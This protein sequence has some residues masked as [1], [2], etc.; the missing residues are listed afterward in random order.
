[1]RKVTVFCVSSII[2]SIGLLFLSVY[3]SMQ[4]NTD[5]NLP[6]Y[7]FPETSINDYD[8]T[9]FTEYTIL[10]KTLFLYEEIESELFLDDDTKYANVSLD[11]SLV[12]KG[13]IVEKGTEIGNLDD[14]IIYAPV[15]GRVIE[16]AS[17]DAEGNV[18]L[19]SILNADALYFKAKIHQSLYFN[20]TDNMSFVCELSSG[21]PIEMEITDTIFEVVNGYINITLKPKETNFDILPGI[22]YNMKVYTRQS[23]C[24]YYITIDAFIINGE[25]TYSE[26]TYYTFIKKEYDEELQKFIYSETIVKTGKMVGYLVGVYVNSDVT[27]LLV[28]RK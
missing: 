3:F 9:N 11:N 27:T 8:I 23:D 12:K 10:E 19:I 22:L 14:E 16:I 26:N 28:K 24:I 5:G 25:N 21:D 13:D 7:E 20:L 18:F 6:N 15:N 1:M 4:K 2:I 17:N